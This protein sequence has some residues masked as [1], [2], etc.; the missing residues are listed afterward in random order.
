MLVAR[1]TIF[2]WFVVCA[3]LG[4]GGDPTVSKFALYLLEFEQNLKK[5]KV[6]ASFNR[7]FLVVLFPPLIL[8]ILIHTYSIFFP[9]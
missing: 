8:A 4:R 2:G 9:F 7:I 5:T 3:N 1:M 6:L